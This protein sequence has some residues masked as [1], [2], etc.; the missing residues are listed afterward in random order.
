VINWQETQ[1]A[2]RRALEDHLQVN[3]ETHYKELRD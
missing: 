3:D 1:Q 2:A